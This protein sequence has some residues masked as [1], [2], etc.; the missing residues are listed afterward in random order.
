MRIYYH[1]YPTCPNCHEPHA[2]GSPLKKTGDRIL[3]CT[4]CGTYFRECIDFISASDK[5]ELT[6]KTIVE[7]EGRKVKKTLANFPLVWRIKANRIER[8]YLEWIC[9]SPPGKFLVTWPWRTVKFIPILVLEYLIRNPEK[10]AV[11]IGKI[12]GENEEESTLVYPDVQTSFNSLL[13]L[14]GRPREMPKK[15]QKERNRFDKTVLIEK[16]KFVHYRVRRRG[17]GFEA[18][19][20]CENTFIRCR[21]SII[22]DLEE[23]YGDGCIRKVDRIRLKD[24][25]EKREEKIKNPDG[26]IDI[27]LVERK[28]Y[29]GNLYYKQRWLWDILLNTGMA[30]RAKNMISPLIVNSDSSSRINDTGGRL[31]IIPSNNNPYNIFQSVK[32]I[33]PDLLIIQN[34]DYFVKD[35]IYGGKRSRALLEYLPA[36]ENCCIVMFSTEPDIRHL[37]GLHQ[38]GSIVETYDI[39]THTWD[40]G[41]VL[42][43][44]SKTDD[45]SESRYPNPLSSRWEELPD[46]GENPEIEYVEVKTLDKLNE[47]FEKVIALLDDAIYGDIR[48][49]QYHLRRSPLYLKGDYEMPEFFKRWGEKLTRITYDIL[50]DLIHEK[51]DEEKL[52]DLDDLMASIY[53][54]KSG[55]QI[56]PIM[57]QISQKINCLLDDEGCYVTVVV[58][59]QDVRGTEKILCDIGFEDHIPGRLSVCSWNEL[60]QKEDSIP[61]GALHFVVSTLPPYLNYSIYSS[62]ISKFIFLGD[63]NNLK[64]IETIVKNRF[65]EARSRP[66]YLL[67]ETDPVPEFL[68]QILKDTEILS[69][70][71]IEDIFSELV[72]EFGGAPRTEGGIPA[73]EIEE[74]TRYRLKPHDTV[75][76]VLDSNGRGMFIPPGASICV[77]EHETIDEI[78]LDAVSSDKLEKILRHRKILTNTEGLHRSFRSIFIKNMIIHGDKILFRK[79]PYEW[80]G[81]GELFKSAIHW[82]IVLKTAV[83]QLSVK[84][85][86]SQ[87]EA[88]TE[89]S[90]YLASLDITAEDPDYICGWWSNYEDVH[91]GDKKIPLYK[92]EH[93]RSMTDIRIIYEGINGKIPEM[94]LRLEDAERSY[95]AAILIQNLRQSILKGKKTKASLHRLRVRLESEIKDIVKTSPIFEVSSAYSVRLKKE[96]EPFRVLGSYYEYIEGD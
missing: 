5:F 55:E 90:E 29:T 77:K 58:H 7:R 85:N 78:N 32:N 39:L 70:Q 11:V 20:K 18:E 22:K 41:P 76:L 65:A 15:I 25:E 46:E 1:F 33:S 80:R 27:K 14:E 8:E 91:L 28:E 96:V 73:H 72:I 87:E 43:K 82:I 36:A 93:P 92:V 74:S 51:A 3:K 31:Y 84:T 75:I 95:T 53:T 6:V 34:T 62:Q 37:Y 57:E 17:T 86:K 13:C 59:Q 21:N 12:S 54:D 26:E 24:G 2:N 16:K 79:G 63:Q 56:N 10:R 88:E 23:I 67:S 81:F 42:E 61:E 40:T 49:Y 4:H 30:K 50:M 35:K 38:E 52:K 64:K 9:N 94:Q 83:R 19:D 44:L 66:L 48:R 45:Q 60:A 68:R 89:L 71:E 69:N 47:F